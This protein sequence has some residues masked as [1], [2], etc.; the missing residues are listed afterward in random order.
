LGDWR[1]RKEGTVTVGR[2]A[3]QEEGYS[4][5]L[6]TGGTGRRIQLQLGDWWYR[7]E[8]T[9]TVWRLAVQEKGYRYRISL[10]R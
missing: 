9:A 5:I 2:L 7:K 8:G 10:H 3:V 4:Y 6:E 1:Y